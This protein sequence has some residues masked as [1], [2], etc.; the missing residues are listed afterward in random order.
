MKKIATFVMMVF[1][2]LICT[3]TF[4]ACSGTDAS[5]SSGVA[6]LAMNKRYIRSGYVNENIENQDF[7]VFYANGTGEYTYHYE[8][9]YSHSHYKIYFKYT[10]VDSDKSAVACFYDSIERLD[11]DGGG[12]VSTK[13]YELVTVSKNVLTTVGTSY[14]FWI[15]E[16]YLK[17][18]P[19]F[20]E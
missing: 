5:A 10:Y 6:K 8:S 17:M 13:W 9:T 1:V 19:H 7:Y 4:S 16:D 11:G 14:V 3:F 12:Y 15:N 2:A 20:G 18:I